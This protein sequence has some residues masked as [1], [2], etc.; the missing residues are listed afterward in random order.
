MRVNISTSFS[1][2][3]S[4]WHAGP[5]S[6]KNCLCVFRAGL[7]TRYALIGGP[8]LPGDVKTPHLGCEAN[9]P[10][11][12]L[13]FLFWESSSTCSF[14]FWN[15][16]PSS[17]CFRGLPDFSTG[18]IFF[19]SLLFQPVQLALPFK[20]LLRRRLR[21]FPDLSYVVSLAQSFFTD[22]FCYALSLPVLFSD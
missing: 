9:L 2:I 12:S 18:V 13:S 20:G 14:V 21:L 22:A 1:A 19:T 11:S 8:L 7:I 16:H 5:S 10:S 15:L 6:G 17:T 4:R 3:A